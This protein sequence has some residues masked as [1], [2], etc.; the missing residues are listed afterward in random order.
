MSIK[1]SISVSLDIDNAFE[2]FVYDFSKWWPREY[3]WS[4]DSLKEIRIGKEKGEMC[5][6]IGP[7]GFRCD[8]GKSLNSLI[9]N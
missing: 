5:T 6:E 3:T 4:R 7:N 9:I 2:T 8:W 1:K